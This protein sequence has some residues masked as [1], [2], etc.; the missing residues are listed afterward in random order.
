MNEI[1]EIALPAVL[2]IQSGTHIPRELR[3]NHL[4]RAKRYGFERVESHALGLPESRQQLSRLWLPQRSRTGR[5]LEGK[6]R[7]RA[8]ELVEILHQRGL[9][10]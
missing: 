10:P 6:T 5:I 7:D 1:V 4:V 8:Q 9:L 2:T 3:L